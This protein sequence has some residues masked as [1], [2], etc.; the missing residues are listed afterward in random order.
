MI[1][2]SHLIALLLPEVTF[3]LDSSDFNSIV[4]AFLT[5]AVQTNVI[6]ETSWLSADLQLMKT[7]SGLHQ[8][9]NII[10]HTIYPSKSSDSLPHSALG[11][12]SCTT[13]HT[14]VITSV[15]LLSLTGHARSLSGMNVN[16]G[17]ALATNTIAL[18]PSIITRSTLIKRPLHFY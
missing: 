2:S 8:N 13:P 1:L 3:F 5:S 7:S 4:S 10:S 9:F 16:F 15:E 11:T 14:A 17:E 12:Y 6:L 18:F